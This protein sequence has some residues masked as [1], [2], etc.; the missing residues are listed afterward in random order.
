ML[1]PPPSS[2]AAF[3][4]YGAESGGA[5]PEVPQEPKRATVRAIAFFGRLEAR[6]GIVAFCDALDLVAAAAE[7][8]RLPVLSNRTAVAARARATSRASALGPGRILGKGLVVQVFGGETPIKG[9]Q[10]GKYVARRS[11]RWSRAG[12]RLEMHHGL[13]TEE[14]IE[15]MSDAGALVVLPGRGDNSPGTVIECVLAGLPVLTVEDSGAMELIDPR[16]RDACVLPDLGRQ[17][18]RH[19]RPVTGFS[20]GDVRQL[21]AGIATRV[22]EG[23]VACRPAL[24]AIT[25]VSAWVSLMQGNSKQGKSPS[26]LTGGKRATQT[27]VAVILRSSGSDLVRFAASLRALVEACQA[28]EMAIRSCSIVPV[29]VCSGNTCDE[30]CDRLQAVADAVVALATGK[31]TGSMDVRRVRSHG[32]ADRV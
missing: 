4:A 14:A 15:R 29:L 24:P 10:A 28:A 13:N 3:R 20:S 26:N 31:T 22:I 1:P 2:A 25:T 16:D 18:I 17:L 8:G 23:G 11:R 7:V 19:E 32:A 5:D 12:W 27:T 21:A 9:E 30:G 6:K